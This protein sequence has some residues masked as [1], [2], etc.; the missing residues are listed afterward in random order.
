MVVMK[1]ERKGGREEWKVGS[2]REKRVAS[3]GKKD[4]RRGRGQGG[5][6]RLARDLFEATG[7]L[8][9]ESV[10]TFHP[11]ILRSFPFGQR[12]RRKVGRQ[13]FRS[14]K[15]P[16]DYSHSPVRPGSLLSIHWIFSERPVITGSFA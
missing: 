1:R 7:S 14:L 12:S 9:P 2:G 3:M 5:G 8:P 6:S 16:F 10:C 13:F 4:G 15:R 11:K